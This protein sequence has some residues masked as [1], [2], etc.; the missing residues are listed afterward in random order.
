MGKLSASGAAC[1]IA[2]A[3]ALSACGKSGDAPAGQVVATVDGIE[4]TA[5]ELNMELAG[6]KAADP[7][8]QRELQDAALQS[9]VG[10]ILLAR[11]AEEQGLTSRPEAAMA[12]RKSEQLADAALLETEIAKSVPRPSDDE[13]RQ[14]VSDN[15]M[16]FANR[17]LFLVDQIIIPNAPADLVK[18]LTPLT[19]MA[20][21]TA[22]LEKSQLRPNS[23]VGVIDALSIDPEATRQITALAPGEIFVS[24]LGT[25]IRVNLVRDTQTIPIT[26]D[27]AIAVAKNLLSSQR[28]ASQVQQSLRGVIEGGRAKVKYNPKFA[29]V[30]AKA[31]KPAQK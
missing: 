1:A 21:V 6:R 9:I 11:A 8:A 2:V 14:F 29:P 13:A 7:Q 4:I 22:E 27:A 25:G 12:R 17:K 3:L 26:G 10:R 16:M 20:Q 28:T 15:P 30:T 5:A 18:R 19:T 24:P 23:T 31:A